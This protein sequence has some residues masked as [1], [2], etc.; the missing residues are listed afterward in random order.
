MRRHGQ[1][2][3]IE[4][5]LAALMVVV[6]IVFTMQFT[7]P[8]KS[9]YIRETSDLRRLAYN[10]LDNYAKAGVYESIIVNGNLSGADW[11]SQ[12]RLMLSMSLPP[13]IVFY[14]EVYEIRF[15][16]ATGS[17]YFERLDHGRITNLSNFSSISLLDA[18]TV[19]FTYVV[20]GR[21]DR[22]RGTVLYIT[23]T[24]GFGG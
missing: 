20:V 24:L 15:D 13:E 1:A 9:I 12:M 23:L 4:M 6:A 21:P 11:E 14:M 8:I 19:T 10:L 16:S 18:E 2:R 17:I 7:R 5:L 3:L 22:V